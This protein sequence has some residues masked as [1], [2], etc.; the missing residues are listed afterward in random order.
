MPCVRS[1]T[2]AD[3]RRRL[4]EKDSNPHYLIQS[5]ASCPFGRSRKK[6]LRSEDEPGAIRTRVLNL[7]TVALSIPLSYGSRKRRR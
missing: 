2:G 1:A 5:Q 3:A 4:R 7:R 6:S